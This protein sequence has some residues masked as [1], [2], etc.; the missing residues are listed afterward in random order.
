MN[1]RR[2]IN[3]GSLLLT[4]SLFLVGCGGS[5]TPT[6]TS[7]KK[8]FSTPL[9][10]EL[11]P[12]DTPIQTQPVIETPTPEK[13]APP[14]T[15]LSSEG[16]WWVF[17]TAEGLWAVNPDGS[18]LTQISFE[19]IQQP[20][21]RQ[22]AVSPRGGHIAYLAGRDQ[23]Y[24]VTLRI[25]QLPWSTM[26]TEIHITSAS[27]EPR[28]DVMPG[29]PEV[30][31]LRAV[32]E[33]KS[34]T[35]SPDGRYLAFMGVI[36]GPTS[37][38]YVYSLEEYEM[39][40]L[41]D[42]PT[43]AIQPVWSPD[44]KYIVHGGVSSLGTGAGFGMQGYWASLADDSGT[45]TLFD[46]SDT[47]GQE[48]IGWVNN[49]TFVVHSW[50]AVC[51]PNQLRT[52]NIKT[53]E[54]QVLWEHAFQAIAFDPTQEVTVLGVPFDDDLC[55]PDESVGLYLVPSD[56]SAGY[57]F[58]EDKALKIIWSENANL[59]LALTDFGVLAIDT[60][61]QFIDLDMPQGAIPFPAVAPGTRELAWPGDALWIGPLLGSIDNPPVAIFSEP[62]HNVTWDPSGQYL[63]FFA[64]SGLYVAQRPDLVPVQI[65]EGLDNR[66]GFSD[67]VMP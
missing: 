46:P 22:I 9:P 44:S 29:D 19:P 51:G 55:N 56:G 30:E 13:A 57:R 64:D 26:I 40:R 4:L 67:W 39:T 61:G 34:L 52:F 43:Q 17:S 31:A 27:S 6:K 66:N 41:T 33:L 20:F 32:T 58:V 24:D 16:P 2:L 18:G 36:E 7:I 21:T 48:V 60:Y 14:D 28:P 42:G 54:S 63:L 3:Y 23:I 62:T 45:V 35:F 8:P 1:V 12:T 25:R 50:N 53:R 15:G 37:D 59:F 47:G 49:Q 10:T 5:A 65:A 38:L 11:P